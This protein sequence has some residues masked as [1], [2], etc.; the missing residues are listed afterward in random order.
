[1]SCLKSVIVAFALSI[2]FEEWLKCFFQGPDD[3]WM[4]RHSPPRGRL[5][6]EPRDAPVSL[7]TVSHCVEIH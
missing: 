5:Q 6:N 3:G 1:M 4:H 7:F 2:V